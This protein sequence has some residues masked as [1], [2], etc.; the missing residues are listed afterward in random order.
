MRNDK[1]VQYT[2]DGHPLQ[3]GREGRAEGGKQG[4]VPTTT[5][6]GGN[7]GKIIPPQ[8]G[9]GTAPPQNPQPKK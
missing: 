7:G 9:S 3:Y 8:G 1:P 2:Q 4:Q 5:N 6:Q